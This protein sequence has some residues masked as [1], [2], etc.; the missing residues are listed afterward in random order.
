VTCQIRDRPPPLIGGYIVSGNTV[1]SRHPHRDILCLITLQNVE[2]LAT[3]A[4]T[5][6]PVVYG[7][8]LHAKGKP[9]VLIYGH[10]DVQPAEDVELWQH[11]PF[12]PSIID[13]CAFIASTSHN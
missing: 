4:K 6:Q 2:I 10:Y 5:H 9:T 8:W 12:K 3:E 13:G 1:P 11:P 7:D